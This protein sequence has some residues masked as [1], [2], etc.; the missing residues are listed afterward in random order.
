MPL[1]QITFGTI[2]AEPA[3][4]AGNY[5]LPAYEWLAE[6]IGFFPHF[7]SVGNND[8]ALYR[9]GY[10]DNWSVHIGGDTV[11]GKYQKIYRKKGEFPNN[12]LLSFDHLEGVFMDFDY[13]HIAINA[14]TNGGSVSKSEMTWILKPS[15]TRERWLRAALTSTRPVDLL[16]PEIPL[17]KANRVRVRN[18]ATQKLMEMKGFRNVD[19]ARTRV[20]S[21]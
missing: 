19:V 6:Q 18:H 2:R 16:V 20:E 13:W 17:D 9:T 21:I 11:D 12:V 5:L 1:T 7:V 14:C 4:S 3:Y 10:Q 15:W 8:S